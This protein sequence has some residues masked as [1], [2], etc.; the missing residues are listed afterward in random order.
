[1]ST[2]QHCFLFLCDYT[3]LYCT[4]D[5]CHSN[6]S[7]CLSDCRLQSEFEG[8]QTEI[9][10]WHVFIFH[11]VDGLWISIDC[12]HRSFIQH[13]SVLLSWRQVMHTSVEMKR[14]HACTGS[15]GRLFKWMDCLHA[16][17]RIHAL[18]CTDRLFERHGKTGGYLTN[19]GHNTTLLAR[20]CFFPPLVF[21]CK[22]HVI[23]FLH[24]PQHPRWWSDT[25]A[26][27]HVSDVDNGS[28][29]DLHCVQTKLALL[30]LTFSESP[31]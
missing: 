4:A 15:E 10:D 28:A 8:F 3:V 11:D 19:K 9:F 29:L 6:K 21:I 27:K 22:L 1:M 16:C 17:A 24:T 23:S 5:W 31:W 25:L 14:N 7:R 18:T 13:H 26:G 12:M 30:Y 2:S 20:C